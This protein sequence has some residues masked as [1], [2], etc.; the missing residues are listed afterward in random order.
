MPPAVGVVVVPALTISIALMSGFSVML[1][2]SMLTVPSL[3]IV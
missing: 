2:R 3:V 1:V